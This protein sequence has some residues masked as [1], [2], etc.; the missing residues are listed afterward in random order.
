[1]DL[2]LGKMDHKLDSKLKNE[3]FWGDFYFLNTVAK[4]QELWFLK[5]CSFYDIPWPQPGFDNYNGA[6]AQLELNSIWN[7]RENSAV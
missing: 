4:N 2:K 6:A 1:M 3:T 5:V 7:Q